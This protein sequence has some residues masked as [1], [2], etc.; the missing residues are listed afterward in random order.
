MKVSKSFNRFAAT[1][2]LCLLVGTPVA[3]QVSKDAPVPPVRRDD[4]APQP[5]EPR[6]PVS[7]GD[8]QMMETMA[9]ANVAE[10]DL[11]RIAETNAA[12]AEVKTFARQMVADH[13]KANRELQELAARKGVKLPRELDAADREFL[14]EVKVKTGPAFDELYVNEA[15][16]KDHAESRQLFERAAKTAEDP[17]LRAYAATTLPVIDRHLERARE[18]SRSLRGES[19]SGSSG[20]IRPDEPRAA[21]EPGRL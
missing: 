10:A 15:A 14:E 6:A 9:R 21:L 11:G 5:A 7:G 18:L 16:V 17:D 2:A 8:R 13:S 4:P 12:S 19:G 20:A 3:A 1:V